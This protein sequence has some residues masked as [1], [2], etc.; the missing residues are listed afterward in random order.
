MSFQKIRALIKKELLLEFRQRTSLGGV[1]LYLLGC[2]Y[3]CYLAVQK[4]N[5]GSVWKIKEKQEWNALLWILLFFNAVIAVSKSFSSETRGR[6]LYSFSIYSPKDF[7]AA[8]LIYNALLVLLVILLS[9][10]FFAVFVGNPVSNQG[11]FLINLTLAALAFSGTL[12]LTSGIAS[13][14][15]GGF[16]LIS[17]LSIPL[18]FPMILLAMRISLLATIGATYA[19]CLNYLLGLLILNLIIGTLCLLLFPYL[20]RE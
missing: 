19:D 2:V 11:L 6:S 14:T 4:I 1:L 3:L 16:T 7:I 17:V 12:T 9:Y 10:F 13:K 15:T 8:K 20:W 5:S 18:L